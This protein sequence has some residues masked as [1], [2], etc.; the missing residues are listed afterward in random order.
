MRLAVVRPGKCIRT[1]A[2][3]EAK[4]VLGAGPL[5]GYYIACPGCRSIVIVLKDGRSM[6]EADSGLSFFPGEACRGCGKMVLVTDG[7]FVDAV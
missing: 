2:P 1:L 6:V 7:E 5:V 3:G 4:R